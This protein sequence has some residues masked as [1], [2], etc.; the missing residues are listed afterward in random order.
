MNVEIME[1]LVKMREYQINGYEI[2][3][4]DIIIFVDNIIPIQSMLPRYI[5]GR[6]V[7]IV[8]SP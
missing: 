5:D 1:S 6:E 8:K 4:S 3:E 2:G 7:T